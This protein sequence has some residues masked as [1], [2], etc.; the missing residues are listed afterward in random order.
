M[1]ISQ[2]KVADEHCVVEIKKKNNMVLVEIKK[3][4]TLGN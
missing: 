3:Y 1:I 4:K 2:A